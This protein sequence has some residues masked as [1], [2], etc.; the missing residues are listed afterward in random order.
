MEWQHNTTTHLTRAWRTDQTCTAT[1]QR[2][3]L[4]HLSQHL[5]RWLPALDNQASGPGKPFFLLQSLRCTSQDMRS[6]KHS[7]SFLRTM[8]ESESVRQP[9]QS[10]TSTESSKVK[11]PHPMLHLIQHHFSLLHTSSW[12]NDR[13]DSSDLLDSG[14]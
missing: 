12:G 9:G 7:P 11:N 2:T 6:E 4:N 8:H 3:G 13:I 5:R 10:T 14:G 1:R